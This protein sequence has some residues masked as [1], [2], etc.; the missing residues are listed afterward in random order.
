MIPPAFLLVRAW[1]VGGGAD[2][3][4]PLLGVLE[5]ARASLLLPYMLSSNY[6]GYMLVALAVSLVCWLWWRR[7]ISTGAVLC[8]AV[9]GAS[10]VVVLYPVAF[11]L[12]LSWRDHGPW[13]RAVFL[14][15]SG[16]LLTFAYVLPKLPSN[17]ARWAT[18]ACVALIVVPGGFVTQHKWHASMLRYKAEGQYYLAHPDRLI[19]S[20]LPASWFLPG[21]DQ[22]Y[23]LQPHSV[24]A[25]T[26]H[27]DESFRR[28]ATMWRYEGGEFVEDPALF[29]QLTATEESR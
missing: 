14:F 28:F 20:E 27:L 10:A 13:Y 18:L 15:G 5:A 25:G 19:Y 3:G 26:A 1:A 8:L 12:T 21:L 29:A 16:V 23:E 4:S 22:M 6:G 11:P 7:L 9:C 2:Y 24:V 17:T